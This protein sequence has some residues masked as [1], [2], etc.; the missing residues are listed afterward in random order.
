M[1]GIARAVEI[2]KA[3]GRRDAGG[4]SYDPAE[5]SEPTPPDAP[6][7]T[8]RTPDEQALLDH[9][10][11]TRGAAYVARFGDSL[12]AQAKAIGDL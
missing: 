6:P 9:F 8:S 11:R 7:P 12:I 4:A 5:R 1:T 10:T 2:L 3:G